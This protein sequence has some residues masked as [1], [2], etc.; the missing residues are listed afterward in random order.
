MAETH[1]EY[2][3]RMTRELR[4]DR[5]HLFK[6]GK[7]SRRGTRK[8][9][10]DM[11]DLDRAI[12]S[13]QITKTE[14]RAITKSAGYHKPDAFYKG[15]KAVGGAITKIGKL[16][17]KAAELPFK[18][19]DVGLDATENTLDILKWFTDFLKD[20]LS[21]PLAL[22]AIGLVLLLVISSIIKR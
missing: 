22:G 1:D 2:V 13:K 15:G 10:K 7:L 21:S 14:A 19:L 12:Q 17:A 11:S 6:G 5:K 4:Y 20:P 8:L 9:A 3:A 18:A 16:T